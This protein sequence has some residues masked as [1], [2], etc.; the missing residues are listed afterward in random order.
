MLRQ[1]PVYLVQ[2]SY[3]EKYGILSV[4]FNSVSFPWD[5]QERVLSFICINKIQIKCAKTFTEKKIN[6]YD[7]QLKV[8]LTFV[9]QTI[10]YIIIGFKGSFSTLTY[11]KALLYWAGFFIGAI[12]GK[13]PNR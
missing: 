12:S 13:S 10:L 4:C 5:W 6:N 8:V 11:C 3:Y 9:W 2:M 1:P 7:I